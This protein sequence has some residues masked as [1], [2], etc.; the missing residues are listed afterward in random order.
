MNTVCIVEDEI[1]IALDLECMLTENG[2][3]V[4]SIACD[5]T[6]ALKAAEEYKPDLFLMDIHVL[7]D[8]DG[9]QIAERIQELIETKIVFHSSDNPLQHA[10][11]LRKIDYLGYL[12]KPATTKALLSFF[13]ENTTH[14]CINN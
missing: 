12:Q 14:S 1:L 13:H 9:I 4:C 3:T 6:S 7:G 5:H 8:I 11:R 2:Y 10:D